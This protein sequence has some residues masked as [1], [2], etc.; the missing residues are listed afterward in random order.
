[1]GA[2]DVVVVVDVVSQHS[3]QVLFIQDDDVVQAF[4]AEC[5]VDSFTDGIFA[6]VNAVR[7]GSG[8]Q[9]RSD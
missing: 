1:M 5:A 8:R 4:P 3:P 2:G 9:V 6:W 7:W